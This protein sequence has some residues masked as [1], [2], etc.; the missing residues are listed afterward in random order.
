MPVKDP[1]CRRAPSQRSESQTRKADH[2]S[3]V[4]IESVPRQG[5]DQ[6]ARNVMRLYEM[7][8]CDGRCGICKHCMSAGATLSFVTKRTQRDAG[9]GHGVDDQINFRSSGLL[10][11]CVVCILTN[12]V[13]CTC[14]RNYWSIL[15]YII[16]AKYPGNKQIRLSEWLV[17]EAS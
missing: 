2:I 5:H 1:R 12:R 15:D 16:C 10:I 14:V 17:N 4:P 9:V 6:F 7:V 8:F 13:V 11:N 3:D